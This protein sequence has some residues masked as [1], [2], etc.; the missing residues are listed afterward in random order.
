MLRFF[1]E[2]ADYFLCFSSAP[3]IMKDFDGSPQV[4]WSQ[5]GP[6]PTGSLNGSGFTRNI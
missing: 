3:R 4:L 2:E 5:P 6:S 1:D